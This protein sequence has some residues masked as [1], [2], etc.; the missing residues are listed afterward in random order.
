MARSTCSDFEVL[1]RRSMISRA[2]FGF[3]EAISLASCGIGG[4]PVM[5]GICDFCVSIERT[6]IDSLKKH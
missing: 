2:R 5:I 3:T 1:P 4:V 6:G